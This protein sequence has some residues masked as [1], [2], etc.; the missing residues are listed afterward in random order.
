MVMRHL[1]WNA[2]AVGTLLTLSPAAKAA[3]V[4]SVLKILPSDTAGMVLVN[5]EAQTWEK[6]GQ[7]PL[8]GSEMTLPSLVA[9]PFLAE[10]MGSDRDFMGKPKRPLSMLNFNI[11]ILP[12]LGDRTAYA[13]LPDGSFITIASVKDNS[14]TQAYLTRL[15]TS[16]ATKPTLLTYN[17]AQIIAWAPQPVKA[18]PLPP[19]G[20]LLKGNGEF[21]MSAAPSSTEKIVLDLPPLGNPAPVTKK[22]TPPMT[23]GFA[24]A[25]LP[26]TQGH[27]IV[28]PTV[29]VL[30]N[31]LDRQ[32]NTSF[33]QHPDLQKTIADPRF[34]T[35]LAVGFGDYQALMASYKKALE[36]F[37]VVFQPLEFGGEL[38]KLEEAY[39]NMNGFL[40]ITPQGLE[41]EATLAF[42]PTLTPELLAILKSNDSKNDILKRIPAVTYGLVNSN[43]LAFPMGKLLAAVDQDKR[44]KTFL[45]G[46][47]K[48][49]QGFLGLDDRDILPWM[50]R[51]YAMFA[52]PTEQGF[53]AKQLQTDMGLGIL[54]QTSDRAQAEAG[55][56]KIQASLVKAL[57]KGIKVAPRTV[58]GTTFTSINAPDDKSLFA[59]S[60]V[61]EDT[62]L[63]V[64]GA[65]TSDRIVPKP[66]KPLADSPAFKEAIAPLPKDNVGYFYLDGSATSALIFNSILP[67][68]FGPEGENTAMQDY[69]ARAGSVRHI[70]GTTTV[71]AMNMRGVGIMQLGRA[72]PSP[73]TAQALVERNRKDDVLSFD[74]EAGIADLS[75]ALTM[76]PSLGEAYFYRGRLRLKTFDYAG[77]LGDLDAATT[78]KFQSPLLAESRAIAYFNLHDYDRALV[79]LKQAIASKE[80]DIENLEALLF[81]A[82]MQTGDYGG[83]LSLINLQLEGD[84]IQTEDLYRRC[85]VKARLGDFKAALAD[86]EAGLTAVR[87]LNQEAQ[88]ETENEIAAQLKA[89]TI[90]QEEADQRRKEPLTS[91]PS[92]PQ[93][94]YARAALGIATALQE[95]E[96]LIEADPEDAKAYEYLGL[97][98]AAL[99]QP[100]NAKQAY[101]QAIALYEALGNQVAVKRVEA[102]VKL[103]PR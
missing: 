28:A 85:D 76:D 26:G 29:D 19:S 73:V 36:A 66:W 100:G 7:F 45:E 63:L 34:A 43:N 80:P 96:A 50:D 69:R 2:L 79:D 49:A 84:G 33:S 3:E 6:L 99:K 94:C 51:E 77:A 47:R 92:L 61:S 67:K 14:K 78:R 17:N 59:Y 53:F 23:P 60:W 90:T 40:S 42:N 62:V 70:V 102:M 11:D 41:A 55:L 12:W 52:F 54:I 91:L 88:K 31:L 103:L 5:T 21:L 58:N 22:P 97:G 64:T 98:R 13:M 101:A 93:R 48:F 57:G 74:A 35:A 1:G 72:V 89:K 44:S 65:E 9:E 82:Q 18:E 8:F 15:Q 83:A 46:A 68:W 10:D 25:Y 30:K 75:R 24:L 27:V 32:K 4:P 20:V 95:C 86:C 38:K 16:R 37:P 56:K 87:A 81:D 39:G 71:N